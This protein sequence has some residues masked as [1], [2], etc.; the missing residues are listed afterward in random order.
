[1]HLISEEEALRMYFPPA[2]RPS[3][4][5]WHKIRDYYHLPAICLGTK[6][7]YWTDELEASMK[8]LGNAVVSTCCHS[9][10]ESIA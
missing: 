3:V 1:M 2:T 4:S 6:T 5:Q 9:I 10:D 8:S 7:L